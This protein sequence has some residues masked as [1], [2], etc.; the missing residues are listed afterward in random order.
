MC[1]L[2][3]TWVE[4]DG[5]LVCR[6]VDESD[7][8]EEVPGWVKDDLGALSAAAGANQPPLAVGKAA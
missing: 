2:K 3:M 1:G 4:S 8:A 7:T 5:Q 6:W